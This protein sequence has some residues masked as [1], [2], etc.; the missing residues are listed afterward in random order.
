MERCSAELWSHIFSFSCTDGGYTGRSLSLV[1]K[2]VRDAS[3]PYKY[4]SMALRGQKQVQAFAK[5]L[6]TSHKPPRVRHLLLKDRDPQ[7]IPSNFIISKTSGT[8]A[9]DAI[10][11][12]NLNDEDILV[13]ITAI[14]ACGLYNKYLDKC[15]EVMATIPYAFRQI[16]PALSPHLESL[17]CAASPFLPTFLPTPLPEIQFPSLVDLTIYCCRTESPPTEDHVVPSANVPF[18]AVKY[19]HLAFTYGSTGYLAFQAPYVNHLRITGPLNTDGPFLEDLKSFISPPLDSVGEPIPGPYFEDLERI[20]L[21]PC[22]SFVISSEQVPRWLIEVA[23]MDK[24]G[25]VDILEPSMKS[26]SS[27]GSA[28]TE[29]IYGYTEV[30]DDW[31]RRIGQL[32]PEPYWPTRR[33]GVPLRL[34]RQFDC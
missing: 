9:I 17:T 12:Y 19:L 29:R 20:T 1:C 6:S 31:K 23:N 2:Y 21:L 30:D 32:S 5:L 27:R 4:K 18:P 7:P 10:F 26:W 24:T 25:K 11:S 13:L 3:S 34:F 33:K 28:F 16:L 15:Q 8:D 22:K 14:S